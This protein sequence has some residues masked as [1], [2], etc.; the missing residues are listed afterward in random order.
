MARK[1]YNS[2]NPIAKKENRTHHKA[3]HLLAKRA[4]TLAAIALC[5]IPTC[6]AKLVEVEYED[7]TTTMVNPDI[8]PNGNGRKVGPASSAYTE[9]RDARKKYLREHYRTRTRSKTPWYMLT[10]GKCWN[11]EAQLNKE[12]LDSDTNRMCKLSEQGEFHNKYKIPKFTREQ[13]IIGTVRDRVRQW[14][15]QHPAPQKMIDGTKN[16]FYDQEHSQW[17]EERGTVW[18]KEVDKVQSRFNTEWKKALYKKLA[19]KGARWNG[20]PIAA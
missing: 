9:I 7:G 3:V 4:A 8:K 5:C 20:M 19:T 12:S 11:Y 15:I 17:I 13:Y 16:A 1:K 18:N 14:E 6:T 2:E 10:S